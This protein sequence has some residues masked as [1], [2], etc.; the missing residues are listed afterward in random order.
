MISMELEFKCSVLK[1]LKYYKKKNPKAYKMFYKELE[2]ILSNPYNVSYKKVIKY[3]KYKRARKGDY[4]ICF[5]VLDNCIY[6]GRIEDR[7]KVYH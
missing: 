6:V 5:K 1:Q 4:R 2:K 7:L 3:P